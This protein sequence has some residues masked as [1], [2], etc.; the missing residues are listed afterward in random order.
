MR[1]KVFF[2][3]LVILTWANVASSADKK[4]TPA[5]S[6]KAGPCQAVMAACQAAG[7]RV[8]GHKEGKGIHADCVGKLFN[9][10]TVAGV[11]V[12]QEQ[13]KECQNRHHSMDGQHGKVPAA[14]PK[15]TTA[16][17]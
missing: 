9:G 6:M 7:Y 14:E 2:T 16:P 13:I 8:G 15:P 4:P 5:P 3:S 1:S 12:T 11:S 17:K 10:E